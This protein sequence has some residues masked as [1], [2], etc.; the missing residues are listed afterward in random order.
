VAP[1]DGFFFK[2]H[3]G[4]PQRSPNRATGVFDPVVAN[5]H[6]MLAHPCPTVITA[7]TRS[8]ANTSITKG[9]GNRIGATT[10]RYQTPKGSGIGL[11]PLNGN[12]VSAMAPSDFRTFYKGAK[13][14]ASNFDR[15]FCGL[16]GILNTHDSLRVSFFYTRHL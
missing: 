8:V 12:F 14:S 15:F 4:I 1:A 9:D 3:K 13:G 5:R 16:D 11:D 7:V 2:G 10:T 6:H